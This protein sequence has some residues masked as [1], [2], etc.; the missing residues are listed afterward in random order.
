MNEY[1]TGATDW[2]PWPWFRNLAVILI[3]MGILGALS[4]APLIAWFAWVA[5]TPA[6]RRDS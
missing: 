1:I 6:R 4:V 2:I 5:G 3:Y